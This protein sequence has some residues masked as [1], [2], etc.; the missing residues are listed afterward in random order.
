[1]RPV[2]AEVSPYWRCSNRESKH[3]GSRVASPASHLRHWPRQRRHRPPNRLEEVPIRLG[4]GSSASR[5]AAVALADVEWKGFGPRMLKRA[6]VA[7]F[8]GCGVDVLS[9]LT[10]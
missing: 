4:L 9:G 7:G 2:P 5:E 1:V 10:C 8:R 6:V 3:L